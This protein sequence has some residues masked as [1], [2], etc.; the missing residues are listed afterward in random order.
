M[1]IIIGL[2]TFFFFRRTSEQV[3]SS[4]RANEALFA[5]RQVKPIDSALVRAGL[6]GALMIV[7]SLLVLIGMAFAGH[8]VMPVAPLTVAA[9]VFGVWLIGLGFGLIASVVEE[10]SPELGRIINL[11]MMPI[12]II[13]GVMLPIEAISEPYRGL[14]LLNPLAH[15]LEIA[16]AG[17]SSYYHVV[18]D[19][20][21]TYLYQYALVNLFFGLIL[22]R[23]FATRL[24][25]Q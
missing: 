3:T 13:S 6:E 19:I 4:V 24:V 12:Y 17:F 5:Y 21:L 11:M 2:M 10:L 7:I 1:W 14:L 15:G 25:M 18:P 16:R 20:S 23:R 9:A 8:H 22:H